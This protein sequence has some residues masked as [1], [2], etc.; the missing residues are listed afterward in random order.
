MHVLL[1][2]RTVEHFNVSTSTV[3]VLFVL[4]SELN[5][6]VLILIAKW[7]KFPTESVKPRVL[8]RLDT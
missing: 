5:N 1:V 6:K 3:D 4:Y 8:R 2:E 7:S